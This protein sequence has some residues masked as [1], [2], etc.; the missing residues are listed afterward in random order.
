MLQP[1]A[2]PTQETKLYTLTLGVG[3]AVWLMPWLLLGGKEAWD[4]ST[5]FLISVPSMSVL[6]GYAAFRARSRWWRWPMALIL[7]QFAT[8]LLLGGFGNLLPLGIVV[9]AILGVPMLTTAALAAWVARRRE[10]HAS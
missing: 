2:V 1:G 4:H 5:Y 10:Q 7:A 9:F 3:V 8:A 6:A